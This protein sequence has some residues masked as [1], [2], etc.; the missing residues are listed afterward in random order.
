MVLGGCARPQGGGTGTPVIL[1]IIDTLRADHLG[2]YG[3]TRPTSPAI[4]AWA[5][6]AG[7]FEHAFAAAPWTLPSFGSIYTGQLPSRHLAG[8]LIAGNGNSPSP[9][10]ATSTLLL[11]EKKSFAALDPAIPTLAEIL[12]Q[13]GYTT[14]AVINNPFLGVASGM[15]RGF[16]SYDYQAANAR[17]IRRADVTVDQALGWIDAHA[18]RPFFLVVHCFDP[19]MNYD[20]PPPFRGRFSAQ[21]ASTL[22]LPVSDAG[23]IRRRAGTLSL[24]DR[25]FI[26]AAYDEEVSFV[27][28]QIGRFLAALDSRG[29]GKRALTV[30]TS[31]H[32]EELFDHGSFEHGHTVYDERMRAPVSLVDLMPTILAA[33]GVQAPP[34]LPGV[35][36]WP[37]LTTGAEVSA[38]G[39]ARA[40]FAEGVLYGTRRQSV[41]RWPLKLVVDLDSGKLTLFNLLADPGE[42]AD[43]GE[44]D[45]EA[46]RALLHLAQ[47]TFGTPQTAV[48]RAPAVIDAATRENLRALGYIE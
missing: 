30:L 25:G 34:G 48:A 15:S 28:A 47:E 36:L 46:V 22:S 23:A 8:V 13:H 40:L 9:P 3:Y 4:D 19:H 18:Q 5:R 20:P 7:V 24:A 42:R 38:R 12:R 39:P 33:V 11:G 44:T 21:F 27:D 6:Q 32:G 31:D 1:I 41:R 37:A 26:T 10:S 29:L 14:G 43:R 16:D 17:Q 45:G 35:S 2:L